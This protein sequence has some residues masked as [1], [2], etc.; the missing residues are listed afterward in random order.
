[1]YDAVVIGL[2]GVGSAALYHLARRGQRVL[3]LEQHGIGHALG[4]SHGETRVIR[5]AYSEDPRY[6]PLLERSYE[7]WRELE[8]EIGEQLLWITGALHFGPPD[9]PGIAG[10]RAAVTE[11]HLAHEQLDADQIAR[12]YP[13]IRPAAGDVGVL[14][15]DGG[16]LA[17][18]RCV[19]GHLEAAMRRGAKVRALEPVLAIEPDGDGVAVVTDR[20][21]ILATSAVLCAGAWSAPGSPLSVGLPLEVTRQV[22]VWLAPLEP[23][24]FELGRFPV[25]V[26]NDGAA[27][28]Y[29]LPRHRHPGVKIC[30]HHGGSVTGPSSI[31]RRPTRGDID[32][33]GAFATA[34]LP[35]AA[36]PVVDARVCMYTNTPDHHFA[37][38]AHP[39]IAATWIAAGF[40]GHGFKLSSVVGEL[41]AELAVDDRT[42]SDIELF[43][44]ARFG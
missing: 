42:S 20:E 30:R 27:V 6:V 32:D 4:S 19:L 40:S 14:E 5:K 2:G 34:H 41:L 39:G 29:G 16:F 43:S 22:Q 1:V 7:L 18:E 21:R 36:G 13:G 31:D 28:F 17:V 33:V 37:I 24:L 26:R 3:G 38:G 25:F 8:A 15:P 12:R 23:E 44:P 9:D 11:H 35:R 10:V